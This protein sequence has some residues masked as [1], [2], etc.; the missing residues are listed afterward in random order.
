MILVSKILRTDG[1]GYWSNVKE[2]V[3][4]VGLELAYENEESSFGEL[5][6]Y[7]DTSVWDV[8]HDGLIYTDRLF[9]KELL[10]ML[11]GLHLGTDVSYSEQGMQGDDYVSCDVGPKFIE[12]YKAL[13]A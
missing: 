9:K 10:E 5:R 2:N 11:S 4:V 3:P 13:K 1:S 7:F 6:V 8:N 12:S